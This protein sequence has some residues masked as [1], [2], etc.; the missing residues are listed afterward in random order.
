MENN[1]SLTTPPMGG[2]TWQPDA[3]Q[4]QVIRAWGGYHLVL[5]PPGCGK[6]QILTERI[7]HAHERGVAYGDML[8]L[9]FTNRAARGMTERIQQHIGTDGVDEVYVGNV[10]RFCARFLMGQ[11]IVEADSSV[12]DEDDAVSILADFLQEDPYGVMAHG[13]RRRE[14]AEVFQFAAFMHQIRQAHPKALRIHPECVKE[15]DVFAMQRICEVQ[16]MDFT[17]QAMIDIYEHTDFYRDAIT[18]DGYDYAARQAIAP[19]LRKMHM[20]RHYELYKRQNHLLDFEDLLLL[21]YDALQADTAHRYKRY[22]WIQVDEVQD[23]N[24]LQLAIID[25]LTDDDGE[26]TVVYLGD[27]QQAIFSFMGAKM[28]QLQQLRKRCEGQLHHLH[29]NHRSPSYLLD[30]YNAYAEHVLAIDKALLP[31]ASQPTPLQGDELRLMYSEQ[32]DGEVA[33]VVEVTRQLYETYPAETTALIVTANHDADVLSEALL[34]R[35]LSHFKVSGQDLFASDGMKLLLAHLNVIANEHNFMAWARMVKGLRVF[36]TGA[37]SRNFIRASLNHGI[38]P[39]DYLR[40]DGR[41]YLRDFVDACH[42]RDIVVFDTETTGLDVFADDIVQIAA[43]KLRGGQRVAGSELSLFIRTQRPIPQKLGDIDNPVIEAMRHQQLHEP[44]EALQ[45]FMD[46]AEGCVL[47]GH[48]ADYDYHMLAENLR[49]YLPH[50]DLA[51]CHPWYLDTLRLVRL[52]EPNMKQH[53]LKHLLMALGLEGENSHL[54]DDDVHATVSVVQHCLA[55]AEALLSDQQAFLERRRVVDR[56]AALHRAYADIYH[57]ARARLYLRREP[58]DGSL[59]V[60]AE[61]LQRLHDMLVVQGTIQPVRGMGYVLA[62]LAND[63]VDAAGEKS[64]AE[65]LGA[66]L[67]TLNTLKEADLCNSHSLTDRIFV[68]TVHKAKGLEFDNVIIF[69]AVEGRYP[70]FFSQNSAQAVAEDARKFYVAMTRARR[71][72]IVAQSLTRID[73]HNQPHEL[74]LTRFMTPI[75]HFFQ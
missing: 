37:A 38:L 47:L 14:Y 31:Q 22:S 11:G 42:G 18:L 73:Y 67:V 72:L 40:S 70:G 25:A 66:H 3:S 34:Q 33:D 62:Y 17:P 55:K 2:H 48:N 43:V 30:V 57:A 65:Q 69:D 53:K 39:S 71:R 50:V 41:T 6:T 59:P 51:E 24:A 20:A 75:L 45:R 46:Y 27:E 63:L 52:L 32:Y 56:A 10:H 74:R 5:A 16:R 54:A 4:Q 68:T 44:S 12:I 7:R 9:T 8:C 35:G 1:Q 29:V 13:R 64:L 26:H 60:L 23:L 49:R 61:E 19:T 58:T 36:E 21:T 28:S 15:Q